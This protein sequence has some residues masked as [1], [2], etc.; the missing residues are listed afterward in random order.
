MAGVIAQRSRGG[1]VNRAERQ[2]ED[3]CTN[4]PRELEAMASSTVRPINRDVHLRIWLRGAVFDYV[5]NVVAVGNLISDWSRE[6]W[7]AIELPLGATALHRLPRLP[8][9][10]L[11]LGPERAPFYRATPVG[12]EAEPE[13]VG[14]RTRDFFRR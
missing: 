13:P 2:P 8:N 9:E 14:I 1:A 12:G 11:Y 5:A 4:W 3:L 6:R 10:R 7:F